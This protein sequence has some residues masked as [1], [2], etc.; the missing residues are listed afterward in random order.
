[1]PSDTLTAR[2]ELDYGR[3][4]ARCP[5]CPSAELV[6]PGQTRFRCSDRNCGIEAALIGAPS[7]DTVVEDVDPGEPPAD[8]IILGKTL[9]GTGKLS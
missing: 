9:M 1:M 7:A 5:S 4:L 2:A 8:A 3:W 6:K